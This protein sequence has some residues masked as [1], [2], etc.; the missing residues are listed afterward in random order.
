M[1]L[2]EKD[3]K[4]QQKPA[5]GIESK[6]NELNK[7]SVDKSVSEMSNFKQV[8]PGDF[9]SYGDKQLYFR[10][11]LLLKPT[12]EAVKDQEKKT[13]KK[14]SLDEEYAERA[15]SFELIDTK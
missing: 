7:V 11:L 6:L 2:K 4:V 13:G 15:C 14:L 3:A 10:G 1:I 5:E 8:I 12:D 9:L